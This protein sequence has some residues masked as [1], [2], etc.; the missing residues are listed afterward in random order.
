M[1]IDIFDIE[2]IINRKKYEIM[3]THIAVISP[4]L[5]I[6]FLINFCVIFMKNKKYIRNYKIFFLEICS[7]F[8]ASK[9]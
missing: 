5:L 7:I 8:V 9:G 6:F 1:I 4:L 2:I 3:T